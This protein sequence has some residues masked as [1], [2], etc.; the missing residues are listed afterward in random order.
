MPI[1]SKGAPVI[2]D[3]GG[4][5]DTPLPDLVS[6]Q[7]TFDPGAMRASEIA[8]QNRAI[9]FF[10]QG[11]QKTFAGVLSN[12]GIPENAGFAEIVSF[13][14]VPQQALDVGVLFWDL[15]DEM[16][17]DVLEETVEQ[18]ME[19]AEV[20]FEEAFGALVDVVGA[21]PVYGW[22][23]KAVWNVAMGIKSIVDIAKESN[24]DDPEQEYPRAQFSPSADRDI[25][26][27]FMLK[28]FRS[29]RNW[30]TIFA[31]P[32]FGKNTSYG[33]RF[34][35]EKLEGGGRRI[36]TRGTKTGWVGFIP[37]TTM[38]HRSFEVEPGGYI[39]RD[40]GRIYPSVRDQGISAW[41][42]VLKNSPSMYTID[43]ESAR[44]WWSQYLFD[45]RMWLKETDLLA[46]D[47]KRRLVNNGEVVGMFGWGPYDM[48]F[49]P[50]LGYEN[51]GIND[52]QGN[53]PWTR[54]KRQTGVAVPLHN[55][56][57]LYKRQLGYLDTLTCA[58]IDENYGVFQGLHSATSNLKAKWEERRQQLLHH[59]AR[60]DVDLKN[61]PDG[62]YQL[63]M[64]ESQVVCFKGP[65][66][67]LAPG[68]QP[69]GDVPEPNA[70]PHDLPDVKSVQATLTGLVID[71][72][73]K[74]L[75]P[76]FFEENKMAIGMLV[77][78][79]G[80]GTYYYKRK[81]KRA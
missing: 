56:E 57:I 65:G 46:S 19:L 54:T 77:L 37:G 78:A 18:L 2:F 74:K 71:Q 43:T 23:V 81:K 13:L 39:V 49:N 47:T 53:I 14:N 12:V 15:V 36:I 8:F 20:A 28:V 33:D 5:L 52:P 45:L 51:F 7:E 1:L 79:A 22:I 61:I 29:D 59:P 66:G 38:V 27:E 44:G 60:C 25:T 31:P 32:G 50:K 76:S 9:T 73:K 26:N 64:E 10:N 16:A 41:G 55:L 63:Q 70:E 67:Q 75:P 42:Q 80:A 35:G 69:S 48:P 34:R 21:I 40:I 72:K 11:S 62:W 4:Q 6:V 68:F 58:Y 30:T 17:E 3:H 24:K